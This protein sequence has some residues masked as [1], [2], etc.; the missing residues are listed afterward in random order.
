MTFYFTYTPTINVAL[1]LIKKKK[2]LDFTIREISNVLNVS[3]TSLYR[4]F[5]SKLGI[6]LEIGTIGFLKL[7]TEFEEII[8]INPASN[9]LYKICE[10]YIK[11]SYKNANY[12]R[13]MFSQELRCGEEHP[14]SFT[15]VAD[16][17]YDYIENAL[18]V[19]EPRK[20]RKFNYN[21]GARSIWAS[22]HGFSQLLIDG[23]FYD[24][25]SEEDI[26]EA[27]QSHLA[28]LSIKN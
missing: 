23:N 13:V 4:H 28:L 10:C 24:L 12:Y 3:H 11:F 20:F 1:D 16:K 18:S 17:G 9:M 27:I 21:V 7:N 5:P 19:T 15:K 8:S 25:K 6:I 2:N 26:I 22:L 14:E